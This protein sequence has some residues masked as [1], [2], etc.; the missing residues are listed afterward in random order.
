MDAFGITLL[1]LKNNGFL[2]WISFGLEIRKFMI[3][4]SPIWEEDFTFDFTLGFICLELEKSVQ[5]LRLKS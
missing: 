1:L 3:I 4:I 2:T 5:E